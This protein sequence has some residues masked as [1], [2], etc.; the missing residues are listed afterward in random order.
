MNDSLKCVY[1]PISKLHAKLAVANLLAHNN[2][3]ISYYMQVNSLRLKSSVASKWASK[4]LWGTIYF[5]VD[6]TSKNVG[7]SWCNECPFL[8]LVRKKFLRSLICS[9]RNLSFL[10]LN[11]DSSESSS[12]SIISC[13]WFKIMMSHSFFK[14]QFLLH[15]IRFK[16]AQNDQKWNNDHTFHYVANF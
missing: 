7:T 16:G 1:L 11:E 10:I 2:I 6:S 3:T 13:I 12:T 15:I 4:H 14:R 5:A 8:S 9:V